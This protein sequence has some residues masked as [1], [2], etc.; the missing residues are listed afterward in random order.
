[1]AALAEDELDRFRAVA[2]HDDLV[3]H[4]G[5]AQRAHR[6][7]LVVGI[8]FHQQ[9]HLVGHALSPSSRK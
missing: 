9:D 6:Q 5:L 3:R 8:V 2:H 1:M 4:L 7:L